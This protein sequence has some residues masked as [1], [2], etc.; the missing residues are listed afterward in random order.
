MN[1]GGKNRYDGCYID[2][3][4]AVFVN[5]TDTT[6]FDGFV[7]GGRGFELQGRSMFVC[8]AGAMSDSECH[9]ESCTGAIASAGRVSARLECVSNFSSYSSSVD[10]RAPGWLIESHV[11]ARLEANEMATK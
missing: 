10:S 9:S 1:T 11:T 2:G 4:T 8:R 6:W 5:P 7:L 3:S